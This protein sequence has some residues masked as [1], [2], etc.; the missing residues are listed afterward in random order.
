MATLEHGLGSGLV[1][2]LIA[3]AIAAAFSV[4]WSWLVARRLTSTPTRVAALIPVW[5]VLAAAPL[6]FNP[7]HAAVPATIA[8]AVLW[9]WPSFRLVAFA[10]GRGRL[11]H[12]SSASS[13]AIALLVPVTY[14]RHSRTGSTTPVA[15]STPA[16]TQLLVCAA[17]LLLIVAIMVAAER[18]APHDGSPIDFALR[19][20]CYSL[21]VYFFASL[22]M[23]GPAGLVRAAGGPELALHFD[24]PYLSESLSEFWSQVCAC[25]ASPFDY[26]VYSYMLLLAP[27]QRWNMTASSVLRESVYE[28][29]VDV[30]IGAP[31]SRLHASGACPPPAATARHFWGRPAEWV[32]AAGVAAVFAAS[33]VAHEYILW[34]PA[35]VATGEWTAFFLLHGAFVLCERAWSRRFKQPLLRG[36]WLRRAYT[37]AAVLISAELLFWPP[38]ERAGVPQRY[39]L[40]WRAAF[41][42]LFDALTGA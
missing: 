30:L 37:I 35:R 18:W 34:V 3:C 8:A 1:R 16:L 12:A 31:L 29:V 24:E 7:Y 22:M 4:A 5:A 2:P 11:T 28:P 20:V 41:L 25:G 23:D 19:H 42:P 9:W 10:L 40:E 27:P 26:S 13:F 21:Y 38:A 39:L 32:R 36:R 17:K 33:G 14:L 6:A 15:A